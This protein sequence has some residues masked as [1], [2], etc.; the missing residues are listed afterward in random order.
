MARGN[1]GRVQLPSSKE[2]NTIIRG[3]MLESARLTNEWGQKIGKALQRDLKA[4]QIR[5][6]FGK[7][8]QIEMNWSSG[9]SAQV[10]QRDLILL[11]PKLRYQS[12][13]KREVESL[14][15]LL[16]DA[17]DLVDAADEYEARDKFQRFVDFFEAI[18]AYHKAEG[19]R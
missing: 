11:K 9:G 16:I 3:D 8:R 15:M 10:A 2:L 7:V 12:E 5:N 1:Q 6:I 19:G 13:R 17:I 4:A 14:A 18:L